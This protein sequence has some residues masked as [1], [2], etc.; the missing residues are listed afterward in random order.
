MKLLFSTSDLNLLKWF[1]NIVAD[2]SR[3]HSKIFETVD[4]KASLTLSELPFEIK[5][6]PF[7]EASTDASPEINFRWGTI[8][9]G[10]HD[11][12]K[13]FNESS[14]SGENLHI[15]CQGG[16]GM[17]DAVKKIARTNKA[18]VFHDCHTP[19]NVPAI[20]LRKHRREKGKVK[21]TDCSS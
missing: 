5:V 2:V 18:W 15:F 20:K 14:K 6:V 7:T 21:N 8:S 17:K 11:Y 4:V 9:I 12:D 10:R 19:D 1:T 3:N 13:C 16:K